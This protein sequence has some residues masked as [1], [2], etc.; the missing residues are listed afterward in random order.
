M[1]TLEDLLR[2]RDNDRM[3]P[4]DRVVIE[5]TGLA[6]PAPVL[7][8]V[9]LHPYLMLRFRIDGVVTVVDAVHGLASLESQE[10]AVLQ[11]AVADALVLTKTD[12]LDAPPAALTARLA[13]LNPLAEMIA[14]AD[15]SA[16]RLLAANLFRHR[17]AVARQGAHDHDHDHAHHHGSVDSIVLT[18]DHPVR[19]GALDVFTDLL[20]SGHGSAL[21]RVK[22]LVA[23]DDDPDRPLLIQGVQHLFHPARRLPAW[24]DDDRRTRVVVIGRPLDGD[25]VRRLWIA[26]VEGP[27]IDRPDADGLRSGLGRQGAGLF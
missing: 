22:G 17:N 12:L 4:F 26:C 5:T 2:R 14:A 23:L 11:A 15:A 3:P 8:A 19:P 25:A 1:A 16:P 20:R 24:P 21:L 18:A 9:A 27:A 13:G 10:E 6:E 7:N